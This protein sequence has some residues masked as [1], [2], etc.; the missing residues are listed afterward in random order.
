MI[1]QSRR[2]QSWSRLFQFLS[3]WLLMGFFAGMDLMG[4]SEAQRLGR[5]YEEARSGYQKS[6]GQST[7]GWV[8]ARACFD[9]AE[10]VSSKPVRVGLAKEAVDACRSAL[11]EFP[12]DV[13]CHYY[14]GLNL[15]IMAQAQSWRDLSCIREMLYL[16]YISQA[17]RLR[18]STHAI[19][20]L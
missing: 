17:T 11:K 4:E 18:R 6:P 12:A 3:G 20:F 14:L 8:L 13:G 7:A 19:F 16:I 5:V 10:S 15:G 1:N 2:L 9:R